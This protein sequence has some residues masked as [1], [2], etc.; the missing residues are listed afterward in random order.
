MGE[1]ERERERERDVGGGEEERVRGLCKEKGN[2]HNN[3]KL[4]HTIEKRVHLLYDLR[5]KFKHVI[6]LVIFNEVISNTKFKAM[7]V[8]EK[9]RIKS[10]VH[11]RH[12]S[13]QP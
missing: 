10:T 6:S 2:M 1:G 9:E 11:V 7:Y 12:E 3:Y 13:L 5:G 4:T 8:K